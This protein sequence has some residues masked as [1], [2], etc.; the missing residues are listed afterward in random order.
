MAKKKD[1]E[2]ASCTN[3]FKLTTSCKEP[4][5]FCP[6]CGENCVVSKKDERPLLNSF[7]DLDEFDESKYYDDDDDRDEED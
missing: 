1:I 7:D 2:C 6:F 3:T 5:S 4:I